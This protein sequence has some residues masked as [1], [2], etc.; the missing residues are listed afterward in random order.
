MLC[1]W[2]CRWATLEIHGVPGH[3]DEDLALCAGFAEGYQT[4]ELIHMMYIN[5]FGKEMCL[6]G[7]T[8]SSNGSSSE[9]CRQ[10]DT[11]VQTNLQYM[12]DQV[13]DNPGSAYWHQVKYVV[14]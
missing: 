2:L 12:H 1:F 7:S 9:F 5:S 13:K 10:L 3:T 14:C 11:L 6:N 8:V 4:A